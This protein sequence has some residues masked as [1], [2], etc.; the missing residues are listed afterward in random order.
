M[1]KALIRKNLVLYLIKELKKSFEQV[2]LN[3]NG[4]LIN[5]RT[6]KELEKAGLDILKIS[7]YSLD[8]KIHNNLRGNK[9]AHQQALRA[10][11][12][13]NKTRIK[14]EVGVLVT[15]KNIEDLSE[16]ILHLSQF[17]NLSFILQPLDEEIESK[18]SKVKKTNQLILKLWPQKQA[19]SDFFDWARNH[20]EKIKNSPANL[21]AIKEYN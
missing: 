9:N 18:L 7:F 20:K 5:Q 8:P 6:A 10:I 3:S 19:V 13:F 4:L 2:A 1:K 17:K 21:Q 11:D 14:T 15:S 16:L 12:I